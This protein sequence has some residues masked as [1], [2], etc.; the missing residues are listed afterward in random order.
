MKKPKWN[1]PG[2]PNWERSPKLYERWKMND[3]LPI[4][5]KEEVWGGKAFAPNP[6]VETLKCPQFCAHKGNLGMGKPPIEGKKKEEFFYK[7]LPL[8]NCKLKERKLFFWKGPFPVPKTRVGKI[9]AHLY[10]PK[11]NGKMLERIVE[12]WLI[13]AT[14]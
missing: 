10:V 7:A 9:G 1:G 4:G 14:L 5:K 11:K 2:G 3:N 6:K 12:V 13:L 8:K